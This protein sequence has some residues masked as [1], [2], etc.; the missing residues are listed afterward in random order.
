MSRCYTVIFNTP[1]GYV[2]TLG[3]GNVRRTALRAAT[4][5]LKDMGFT[6]AQCSV[7]SITP[8]RKEKSHG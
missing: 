4:R 8:K 6:P 2:E 3:Y 1:T 7:H 5:R